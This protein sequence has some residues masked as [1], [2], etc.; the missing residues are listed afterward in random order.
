M[1]LCCGLI[2]CISSRNKNLRLT[3]LHANSKLYC[4]LPVLLTCNLHCTV[5]RLPVVSCSVV[6]VRAENNFLMSDKP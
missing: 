2:I 4:V 5:P 1:F 6:A 3:I